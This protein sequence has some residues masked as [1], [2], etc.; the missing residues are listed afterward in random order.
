MFLSY[1]LC[2]ISL[3]LKS[4]MGHTAKVEGLQARVFCEAIG[5]RAGTIYTDVIF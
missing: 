5:D 4:L 3:Y 2:Y 1:F